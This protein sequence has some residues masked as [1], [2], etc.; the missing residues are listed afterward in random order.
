MSDDKK[1]RLDPFTTPVVRAS[2]IN[3]FSPYVNKETGKRSFSL[4]LMFPKATSQEYLR[5]NFF[6]P[7][8]Q[9]AVLQLGQAEADRLY[10]LGKLGMPVK[11]GDASKSV[12]HHGHFLVW[13]TS[14]INEKRTLEQARPRVI[15]RDLKPISPDMLF[16]GC[17]VSAGVNLYFYDRQTIGVNVGLG[18]VQFDHPGER[19]SGMDFPVETMFKALEPLSVA[20]V[21]PIPGFTGGSPA[22]TPPAATAA[23]AA[24]TSLF[25]PTGGLPAPAVKPQVNL[26]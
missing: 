24:G 17:Y 26:F 5:D 4:C 22:F 1:R 8:Y 14:N 16:S 11:D 20:V 15:G 3:V 9:L 18:A 7:A 13:C 6:K 2:H 21:T 10:Q 23:P 25:P 12:E 19:M